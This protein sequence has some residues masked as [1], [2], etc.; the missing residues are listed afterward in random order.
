MSLK[1]KRFRGLS[2]TSIRRPV[3]TM[4]VM[5]VIVVLGVIF[6]SRLPLDLLP[7][8]DYPQVR[9]SV[10]NPGVEPGVLEETVAKPLERALAATENL[11]GIE[12]EIQEGRVGVNLTFRYGTNVDFALQDA[13]KNLERV[14]SRL[15]EEADPP[16]IFKFDP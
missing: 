11:D 7:R 6:L 12:T 4:M 14:R 8:I 16:T 2:S 5:S 15:P 10:N 9:V 3:G 13:S 1:H